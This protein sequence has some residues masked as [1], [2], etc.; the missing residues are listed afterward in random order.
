VRRKAGPLRK[1]GTREGL[2]GTQA[3]ARLQAMM[4]DT[5]PAPVVHERV[6]VKQASDRLASHLEAKG[7]KL[8]ADDDLVFPQPRTGNPLDPARV[9][10]RFKPRSPARR[11][12][13]CGSTI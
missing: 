4:Q 8:Q 7:S 2:N 11:S 6:A 9:R 10:L 12:G 3:E 5:N 13:L 1:P